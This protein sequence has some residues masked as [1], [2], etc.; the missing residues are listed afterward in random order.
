MDARE[1]RELFE[2]YLDTIY[3]QRRVEALERFIAPD[4]TL[5]PPIPGFGP[6]LPG[7]RAAVDAWL[8][9]FSDVQITLEG[10]VYAD[11][12]IAPR[13]HFTAIHS[14]PFMGIPASGRRIQFRGHPQYRLRDGKFVE[15]WDS[16]D[17]LP[18]MQ[19][20]GVFPPTFEDASSPLH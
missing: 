4:I 18:V 6:G 15:F 1:A 3:H 12:M 19:Q 11:D 17:L 16:M 7:V 9:A 14:G 8:A 10:F 20:L 2:E 13:L 5:H